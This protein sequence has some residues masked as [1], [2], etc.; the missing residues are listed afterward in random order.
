MDP[1]ISPA[2]LPGPCEPFPR[3]VVERP[4]TMRNS[5]HTPEDSTS[6]AD[7]YRQP[8]GVFGRT[9]Y[10][11]G[12]PNFRYLWLAQMT[13]AGAFWLQMIAMPILVLRITDGSAVQLGLVMAARTL[14]ALILGL[15]AGVLADMWDRRKILISTRAYNAIIAAGFA[16]AIFTGGVELWHTYTY[17]LLRGTSQA[18]EQTTRR[19]MVGSVVPPRGVVNAIALM[20]SSVQIMRVTSAV[21]GGIIIAFFNE[22]VVFAIIAVLAAVGVPILLQ[23]RIPPT[24]QRRFEGA[25]RVLRDLVEGLKFA[26]GEPAARGS[27]ITAFIYFMFGA[28]FIQVFVPLVAGPSVLGLGEGGFGLLVAVIGLGGI[29][30]AL[31][32]AFANPSH[33]RG[34]LLL[35]AVALYGALLVIFSATTYLPVIW[36][37]FALGWLVG[38]SQST[39]Q[40]LI[41]SLLMEASPVEMRGRTMALIGLDQGFVTLG[42]AGAG[43]A[44][45]LLGT[46]VALILFGLVCALGT[47]L[48]ALMY[49]PIRKVD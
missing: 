28:T 41:T 32:V 8:S 27:L 34:L 35:G 42:A 18:F 30:G 14:P 11:I 48:L 5:E 45:A 24:K 19:A 9:F 13:S 38:V 49:P 25:G 39:F 33:H 22:G 31:L 26:W 1:M 23:L 17:A 47:G 10:A 46:Q 36:V 7:Q 2:G 4:F 40:P 21:L 12:Y 3:F 16:I 15:W 37:S 6:P 44:S 43:F 20:S 29:T